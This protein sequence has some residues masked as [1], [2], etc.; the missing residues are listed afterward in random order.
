MYGILEDMGRIKNNFIYILQM[1]STRL[2]NA[3]GD[4]KIQERNKA[5]A[6]EYLAYDYKTN[7]SILPNAG[8]NMGRIPAYLLSN[9]Q[10][11]IDSFL[12]GTYFNNLEDPRRGFTPRIK[13]VNE[14]SY[15]EKDPVLMPEPLIVERNQRP[16]IF[17]R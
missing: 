6:R 10:A 5:T 16:E 9:N 1:A 7:A 17:R 13:K 8:I 12:K 2:R 15:F 14:V 4:Y 11:D 3:P